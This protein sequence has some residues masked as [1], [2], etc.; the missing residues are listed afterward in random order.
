MYDQSDV[1]N[2]LAR[3]KYTF[4]VE[5]RWQDN[6]CH[7]TYFWKSI[8]RENSVKSDAVATSE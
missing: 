3:G 7:K 1:A 4:V 2:H 6:V 5:Q 8:L